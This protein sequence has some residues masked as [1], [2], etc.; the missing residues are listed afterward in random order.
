MLAA[1]N[2]LVLMRA[3]AMHASQFVWYRR[4]FVVFSRYSYT[5]TLKCLK[6]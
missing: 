4:L 5:N 2:P 6:G 3:M 1:S